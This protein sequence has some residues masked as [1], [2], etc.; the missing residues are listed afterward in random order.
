MPQIRRA[1]LNIR[2]PYARERVRELVHRTGMTATQVVEEAL[3]A[4]TPP[5]PVEERTGRLV[6][7]GRLLVMPANGRKPVT[8]EETQAAIEAVRTE[9]RA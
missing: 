1:Q 5:P 9:S 2:S 7:K 3:R 4:Y 6:R 8:I